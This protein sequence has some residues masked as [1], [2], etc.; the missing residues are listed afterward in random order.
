M[1]AT[2]LCTY[3]LVVIMKMKTIPNLKEINGFLKIAG[4]LFASFGAVI[5]ILGVQSNT[6]F[7]TSNESTR[8]QIFGFVSGIAHIL[9]VS[10]SVVVQKKY[11][12]TD[13]E[14]KWNVRS[15]YVTAS[16]M[17]S[18]ACFAGAVCLAYVGKPKTFMDPISGAVL[19]LLLYS[20][21]ITTG[22]SYTLMTWCTSQIDSSVVSAAC[23]FTTMFC[24]V[25]AF[26]L[27]GEWHGGIT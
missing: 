21:F 23:L 2:P 20:I 13:C 4:T 3:F 8:L 5:V 16:A 12:F 15:L 27:T 10:L 24:I 18:Y 25:I 1:Q 6:G 26:L 14:S 9:C 11:I 7:T 19:I 22:V 17:L